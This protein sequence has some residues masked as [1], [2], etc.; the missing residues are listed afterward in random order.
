MD[1]LPT[2]RS[3]SFSRG[4]ELH[5]RRQLRSCG[6]VSHTEP[7][8]PRQEYARN[9]ASV[10]L[11]CFIQCKW[12]QIERPILAVEDDILKKTEHE[13]LLLQLCHPIIIRYVDHILDP[14]YALLITALHGSEGQHEQHSVGPGSSSTV[15][16]EDGGD[17]RTSIDLFECID[18]HL[19]EP[20]APKIFAQI[21]LAVKHMQ[22]NG[23]VH[24]KIK[25]ENIV[26]PHQIFVIII[27]QYFTEQH[28]TQVQKSCG[29]NRTVVQRPKFGSVRVH[30]CVFSLTQKL[31]CVPL[32]TMVVGTSRSTTSPAQRVPIA[33][34]TL[35]MP[36]GFIWMLTRIIT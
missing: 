14:K 29:R 16:E 6:Q 9:V 13:T 26:K 7:C 27:S 2:I 32:H 8:Q 23:I 35:R 20:A 17:Q 30:R 24:R 33:K 34:G 31:K 36:L 22:V 19:P 15:F 12:K 1:G 11:P 3:G 28:F 5:Q 10:Q 18:H 21:A 25:D 4:E